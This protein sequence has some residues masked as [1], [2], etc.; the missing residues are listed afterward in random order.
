MRAS[1]HERVLTISRVEKMHPPGSEA[2]SKF[3]QARMPWTLPLLNSRL[4]ISLLNPRY[5]NKKVLENDRE[6]KRWKRRVS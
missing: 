4:F 2:S 6:G 5:E 1:S 3:R